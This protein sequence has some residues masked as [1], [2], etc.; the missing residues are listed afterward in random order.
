ML[1]AGKPLKST[2]KTILKPLDEAR[3]AARAIVSTLF[4]MPSTRQ[5]HTFLPLPRSP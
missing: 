5:F 2:V 1:E 3:R 4:T